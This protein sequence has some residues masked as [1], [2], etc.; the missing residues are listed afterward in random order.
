MKGHIQKDS[1]L[2]AL[3]RLKIIQ[4]QV[5]GLEKMVQN[6]DYCIDILNQSLAVQESL[7]SFDSMMLENHIKV[8]VSR[9]LKNSKNSKILDEIMQ[10]Y[11]LHIK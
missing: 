11:K 3:H 10:L 5:R 9:H 8:H 1:K 2:R 7:K 6:E 4:G